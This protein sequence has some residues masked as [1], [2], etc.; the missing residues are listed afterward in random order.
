MIRMRTNSTLA[1][2]NT[3]RAT[4]WQPYINVDL[5][6]LMAPIAAV[7]IALNLL[8][9]VA[10][11]SKRVGLP[12]WKDSQIRSLLALDPSAR[13]HIDR[14]EYSEVQHT[15]V[16]LVQSEHGWWLQAV[17]G[18]SQREMERQDEVHE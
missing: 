12:P 1:A 2:S 9:Y 11:E 18:G 13:R 7:I 15:P 14:L 4:S 16:R 3:G 6:W 10:L 8:F 17:R 5:R